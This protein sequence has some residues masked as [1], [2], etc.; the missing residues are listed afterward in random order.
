MF[1][2]ALEG[3]RHSELQRR[4]MLRIFVVFRADAFVNK[5]RNAD[6]THVYIPTSHVNQYS[7]EINV[8]TL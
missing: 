6:S 5:I 3:L 1:M 8:I 4:H 2:V 7:N